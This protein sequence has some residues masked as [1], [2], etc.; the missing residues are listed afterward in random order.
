MIKKEGFSILSESECEKLAEL[1]L[2][3]WDKKRLAYGSCVETTANIMIALAVDGAKEMGYERKEFTSEGL[4]VM[5]EISEFVVGKNWSGVLTM[6]GFA[7]MLSMASTKATEL[8]NIENM[9]DE[10]NDNS[11]F[12]E[13]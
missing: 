6:F 2:D 9:M 10:N 1:I 4:E 7:C 11:D 3:K 8:M 5:N 13:S 12:K